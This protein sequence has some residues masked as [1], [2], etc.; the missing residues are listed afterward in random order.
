MS[1]AIVGRVVSIEPHSNADRLEVLDVLVSETPY[2]TPHYMQLVTGKHYRAGDLGVWLADGARI[3]GWLAYQ[4]WLVG[5]K[6]AAEPFEVRAMEIRGVW[7]GGLWV[8]EWYRN[9]SSKES[10]LRADD[11]RRGGGAEVDGWIRWARWNQAWKVGDV[12]AEEL[13]IE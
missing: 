13:G 9:D 2:V 8:G 5:K 7:S 12:V 1:G 11:L 10:A 3:P 4:L 6:R